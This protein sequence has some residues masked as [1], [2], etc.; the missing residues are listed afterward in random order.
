MCGLRHLLHGLTN[1]GVAAARNANLQAR[2][3]H[4]LDEYPKLQAALQSSKKEKATALTKLRQLQDQLHALP[5]GEQSVEAKTLARKINEAKAA[6]QSA[7]D[8]FEVD[9]C[10]VDRNDQQLKRVQSKIDAMEGALRA[11]CLPDVAGLRV[12]QRVMWSRLSHIACNC[13]RHCVQPQLK[14]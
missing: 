5:P 13:C 6:F 11:G 8:N 3:E 1:A 7:H 12:C 9:K 10:A 2:E 4:L 14:V